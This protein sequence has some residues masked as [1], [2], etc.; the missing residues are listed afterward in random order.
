[1]YYFTFGI[2]Q[3]VNNLSLKTTTY[4]IDRIKHLIQQYQLDKEEFLQLVSEGLKNSLTWETVFKEEIQINHLKRIDKI[5][6]KGLSYYLDPTPPVKSKDSSIFFRKEKFGTNLNLAAKKIVNHFEELKISL[7]GLA[8]LSDINLERKIPVFSSDDNPISVAN[9]VRE[10]LVPRFKKDPKK[11]LNALIDKFAEYNILV[12]E[13]VEHPS[14]KEKTNIDGFFLQPNAIVLRRNQDY[15]KREIFT[16]AHELGHYLLNQEEIESMDYDHMAFGKI[17]KIEAWCNNFAFAFL[18]G[19]EFFNLEKLPNLTTRND[20]NFDEVK[21]IS[22]QTHLSFTAILTY[23]VKK[24]KV[25]GAIYAKMRRDQEE[26]IQIRK[27]EDK[28]KRELEKEMGRATMASL[29]KP[30][31]SPLFV[32]TLQSAF[33]DGVINEYELCKT[34]NLKPNQLEKYL[35]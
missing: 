14:L 6:K 32:S 26:E 2:T 34:L 9:K 8:K 5:F 19:S 3:H 15:F 22:D 25:S 18:A 21:A 1:L 31:Q 13:Y 11:F 28:K 24:G 10:Q 27:E 17:N 23:L 35:R 4:N 30:I 29:A 16:L 20:Y 33:L 12:F 7:S